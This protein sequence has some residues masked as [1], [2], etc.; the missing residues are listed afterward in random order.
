MCSTKVSPSV[1]TSWC[2]I[3]AISINTNGIKKNGHPF[4]QHIISKY[5][6]SCVQD[7]RFQ[8]KHHLETFH[9]HLNSACTNKYFIS[10]LNSQSF[11]HTHSKVNGV[12]TIIRA[13]FPGFETAMMID[14]LIIINRYI[15][16]RVQVNHAPI[17]IHNVY[18][19][20]NSSERKLF[21]DHL[22]AY[23]FET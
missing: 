20:V 9:F 17:Y 8:D 16:V 10:D 6:I 13:D 15:V 14:T 22:N 19:T 4:L 1:I 11:H 7:T 5:A 23:I 12:M 2:N 21:F 3:N 18:A